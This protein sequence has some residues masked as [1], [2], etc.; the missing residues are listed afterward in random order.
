MVKHYKNSQYTSSRG[1]DKL[2]FAAALRLFSSTT[3]WKIPVKKCAEAAKPFNT[4][5]TVIQGNVQ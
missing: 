1:K 5:Q 3:V 2:I 4:P